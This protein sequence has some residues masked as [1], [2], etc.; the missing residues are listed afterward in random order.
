[1]TGV[2]AEATPTAPCSSIW[3]GVASSTSCRIAS[4]TRWRPGCRRSRDRGANFAD[5]ATR[6]APQALQVADRFHI[7]KNLVEALQQVVGREQALLQVAAQATQVS[8]GMILPRRRGDTLPRERARA[9][10]QARRQLRYD[11]CRRLAAQGKRV[12]EIASDLHMGPNTVRR[13]LRAESCPQRAAVAPH[14]T[15]LSPFEPYLRERW[16]AGEQNGRRLFAEIR[17]RG[18]RGSRSN[19]YTFLAQWRP[20]PRRPGPYPRQERVTPAPPPPPRLTP[21]AVGWLLV[22]AEC[23]YT[24]QEATFVG[25][26][27]RRSPTLVTMR[28]A[29]RRFFTLLRQRQADGLSLWLQE[30]DSSGIA[31]LMAF[32]QGVCRDLAAIQAAFTSPWSQG[33]TEGHVTRLKLL[34]RQ[35]YGRANFDLLRQRVLYRPVG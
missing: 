5:G 14:R 35:M 27:L 22:R 24:P 30:A 9:A 3:N 4:L 31:E 26:I 15:R 8:G 21:R 25:E 32:A 1:M 11:D 33:Q 28:D 13:F 17:T 6:G 20:G 18:Y 29:V 34:K 12:R 7:L 10:A 2:Y 19:L 23:D 16:D